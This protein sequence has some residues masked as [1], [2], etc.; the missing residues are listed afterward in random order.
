MRSDFVAEWMVGRFTAKNRA[1]TI[2]G[3]LV[4]LKPQ[5]GSSWFWFSVSRVV[6]FLTWRRL[7]ALIAALFAAYGASIVSNT[8][9]SRVLPFASPHTHLLSTWEPL[10]FVLVIGHM[11]GWMALAYSA[12]RYGFS[13]K[14]TQFTFI[15][16]I[17]TTAGCYGWG[18][19]IVVTL[20]I[21]LTL[22]TLAACVAWTE[23][24]RA[25]LILFASILTGFACFFLSGCVVFW[26][27]GYAFRYGMGPRELFWTHHSFLLVIYS[28]NLITTAIAAMVCSRM[29]DW[30]RKNYVLK[31]EEM[32]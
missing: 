13:D 8:I 21:L 20:C 2:V 22:C 15:W 5:K 24:R 14:L 3:D 29:H 23:W 28:I 26:Y 17:V 10:F 27:H 9:G 16:T 7:A 32:D 12:I 6:L 4:E 31:T 25:A 19:P 11:L 30:G 1:A 18:Q